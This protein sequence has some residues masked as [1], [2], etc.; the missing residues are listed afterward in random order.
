[1]FARGAVEREIEPPTVQD[2]RPSKQEVV[3]MEALTLAH[4]TGGAIG[5]AM[6]A[7]ALL[8]RKGSMMHKR[9][10]TVFCLGMVLMAS[11]GG[12]LAYWVEKPFDVLSS[13]MTIY[14]VTT[15]WATFRE[16]PAS[17]A[18]ALSGYGAVCLLGYLSVEIYALQTGMRATD[19]PA[20]AGYV[21][22]TIIG[23]AIFG[24]VK[25]H[26]GSYD[27]RRLSVRHMWR[28][29]FA[30]LVATASFFGARPHLF[31]EWM[32]TYGIL[33][34]LTLAPLIFMAY[35]RLRLRVSRAPAS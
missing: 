20:G 19:A 29:N 5:L 27:R 11:T 32:Q 28:M 23:L 33:L 17:L 9:C 10:G 16:L 31:P 6:G 13:L 12:I 26:Q 24:D 30:L 35:W 21:F 14:F 18:T 2:Q 3:N 7:A 22:A 4:I 8:L 1:M 15:A 25:T 34:G